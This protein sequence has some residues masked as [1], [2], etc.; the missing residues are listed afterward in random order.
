MAQTSAT[1]QPTPTNKIPSQASTVMAVAWWCL[2]RRA[3]VPGKLAS[4]AIRSTPPAMM[5][6]TS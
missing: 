4:N 3:I 1:I 5:P 2:F 6:A